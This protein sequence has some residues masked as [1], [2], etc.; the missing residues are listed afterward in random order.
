MTALAISARFEATLPFAGSLRHFGLNILKSKKN[1]QTSFMFR[2]SQK[3]WFP[4]GWLWRMFPGPPKQKTRAQ[5]KGTA[6]QK[7]KRN[8]GTFAKATLLGACAMTT[9]ILDNKICSF[10]ILLSWRFPRKRGYGRFSS[11]SPPKAP[12]LK[13]R[14]FYYYCRVAVS[15]L[16]QNRPFFSESRIANRTISEIAGLESPE[17]PQQEAKHES[18]R[19]EV[20][21]Q[22]IDSESP[23]E[24]HLIN[25]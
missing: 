14:K 20:E 9:K 3:G 19:C 10:K 12:P 13:K 25:A 2:G 8:K 23:S 6:A 11:L 15:D 18:N 5:K 1:C 17:S 22:K 24:S 7:K 21:L 4:K 16:L